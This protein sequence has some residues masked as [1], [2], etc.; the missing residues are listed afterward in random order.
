MLSFK[1]ILKYAVYLFI[2]G[3]MFFL[4]IV[5]GRGTS[6]VTFDTQKF[7]ERLETIVQEFG[8]TDGPE[9]EM[10]LQFYDALNKPARQEV[11]GKKNNP[12]EIFPKKEAGV[13]SIQTPAAESIPVKTSRKKA[14][15]NK[16]G[17]T[18]T[19]FKDNGS[20]D[21]RLTYNVPTAKTGTQ[22]K[23]LAKDKEA[24]P[25]K[26]LRKVPLKTMDGKKVSKI[27]DPPVK[28]GTSP[29]G[30]Q[31]APGMYTIQIAAYKSFT[32]AVTQMALLEKKGFASYRT[33]GKKKGITWYRV[34]VGS[35]ATRKAASLYAEKLKH[36]KIEAMIIK[37][38]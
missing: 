18:H 36:A 28:T 25:G 24:S 4:G 23:S 32:D 13:V 8:K 29:A 16:G 27:E 1:G 38:E 37:K 19:Q 17:V 5:V 11:T 12:N 15:M 14:T 9:E 7:H 20:K 33:L 22:I 35:F 6:P 2:G 30:V 26:K 34:R 3:W 10:D 21:A 31:V